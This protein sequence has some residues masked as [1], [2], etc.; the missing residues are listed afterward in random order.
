MAPHSTLCPRP[1]WTSYTVRWWSGPFD[2]S[3]REVLGK[4]T[5]PIRIGPT[6]FDI[7]FYVIDIRP[8]YSC[9]L[10]RPWIHTV[11]AVPSSLHQ[12]VKFI[13]DQQLISVMG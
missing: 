4:I 3:K 1:P 2:G 10:G 12:K 5:L 13:A 9:L 7:T 11:R 6:M 8:A